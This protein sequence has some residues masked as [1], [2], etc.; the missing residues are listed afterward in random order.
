MSDD[1]LVIE[2][3]SDGIYVEPMYH[4]VRLWPDSLQVLFHGEAEAFP[5]ASH[6]NHKRIVPT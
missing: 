6:Y 5:T 1:A 4:A 3:R 2:E